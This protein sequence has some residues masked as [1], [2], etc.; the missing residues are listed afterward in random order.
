M[1]LP[2][3]TSALQSIRGDHRRADDLPERQ[4]LHLPPASLMA[5]LQRQLE[6]QLNHLGQAA[7]VIAGRGGL[8][9]LG[10]VRQVAVRG[11]LRP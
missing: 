9:G 2:A 11:E 4:R 5:A 8:P 7:H 3:R 6:L 10:E 1:I